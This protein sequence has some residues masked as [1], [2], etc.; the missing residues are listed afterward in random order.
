MLLSKTSFVVTLSLAALFSRAN[1][2]TNGQIFKDKNRY[3]FM[4]VVATSNGMLQ[5]SSVLVSKE[6][7]W[8]LTAGRCFTDIGNNKLLSGPIVAGGSM[9]MSEMK[10]FTISKVV[11]HPYFN[12]FN[13]ANDIALFR[14]DK[15]NLD[16]EAIALPDSD[17]ELDDFKQFTTLGWG[18]TGLGMVS[19]VV[20]RGNVTGVSD[21]TGV[22]QLVTNKPEMHKTICGTG[23]ALRDYDYG[24]PLIAGAENLDD[25][26]N[27]TLVGIGSWYKGKVSL[28][29]DVRP[30][31][32]WIKNVINNE[33]KVNFCEAP[34]SNTKKLINSDGKECVLSNG[35]SECSMTQ[36]KI[37][38]P[39]GELDNGECNSECNID[40]CYY[41]N[42]SCPRK[43]Y[44]I[45]RHS[46][47]FSLSI[48]FND[49]IQCLTH[50]FNPYPFVIPKYP[51]S[52]SHISIFQYSYSIHIHLTFQNIPIYYVI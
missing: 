39:L 35:E 23:A 36:C 43:Y 21:N 44:Q 37:Y 46:N 49:H 41:D 47:S 15:F 6:K 48:F 5:C 18:D 26:A 13:Y 3:P 33:G 32:D 22:C 29:T 10:A 19:Q 12:R 28:F 25:D 1:G 30:Y 45:I 14:S 52:Y 27:D 38:C 7:K 17:L 20:R 50:I 9:N 40:S 8:F 51:N 34:C 16:A 4:S 24:S 11:V 31:L 2:I 42:N